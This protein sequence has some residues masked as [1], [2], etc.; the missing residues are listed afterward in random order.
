[1]TDS[2]CPENWNLQREG[3]C[4]LIYDMGKVIQSYARSQCQAQGGD[5]ISISDSAEYDWIQ[6]VA[7]ELTIL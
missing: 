4:Y 3:Y 1:M 5:L 6:R 7:Y 2:P